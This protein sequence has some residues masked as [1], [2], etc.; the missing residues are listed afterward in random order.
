MHIAWK[1]VLLEWFKLSHKTVPSSLN[2]IKKK[3]NASKGSTLLWDKL[4]EMK[5]CCS[6]WINDSTALIQL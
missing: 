4:S 3:M 6:D 1:E 2:Q 5:H